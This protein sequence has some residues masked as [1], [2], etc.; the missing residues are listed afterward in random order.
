MLPIAETVSLRPKSA[1]VRLTCATILAAAASFPAPMM[2]QTATTGSDGGAAPAAGGAATGGGLL[3]STGAPKA[4][5]DDGD[6]AEEPAQKGVRFG[7]S[8]WVTT[9][10]PF[11][12]TRV[13]YSDNADLDPR[14]QEE[15]DFTSSTTVGFIADS[16]SRRLDLQANI[17][18]TYDEYLDDTSQDG[19]TVRGDF[20]GRAEVLRNR[21]FLDI[22]GSARSEPTEG[23][24]ALSLNETAAEDDR[25][26]TY[27]VGI[28]PSYVQPIDGVG[29]LEARYTFTTRFG[30][31]DAEES[32]ASIYEVALRTDPQLLDGA[33]LEAAA[34]FED[35]N[36]DEDQDRDI[37]TFS[38]AGEAPVSRTVAVI[39]AV[40][41]DDVD[42]DPDIGG[43]VSGAFGLAGLRYAP[44]SRLDAS[45]AAGVRYNRL[46]YRADFDY[47]FNSMWSFSAFGARELDVDGV[48]LQ[49][50]VTLSRKRANAERVAGRCGG[51]G[52]NDDENGTSIDDRIAFDLAVEF[53]K[54]TIGFSGCAEG[55]D[56][57]DDR[58]DEFV[59]DLALRADRVLPGTRWTLGGVMSFS[60]VEASLD[61]EV[62]TDNLGVGVTAA[63]QLTENVSVF[64]QYGFSQRFADDADEEYLENFGL[65]GIRGEL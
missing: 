50:A 19:F 43:D 15:D 26:Q 24:A 31:G 40:G 41:F 2:A 33:T 28:S 6:A 14:G 13:I 45:A 5:A 36:S 35:F 32:W 54:T 17:G 39:G 7:G 1:I 12:E 51:L 49:R 58:G 22:F 4:D 55:R 56:F 20:N 65:I 48:G 18:V 8:G 42:P 47:A 30:D 53:P 59:W 64:A 9:I 44:N 29:D 61:G 25:E 62:D 38:L 34:R 46:S 11:V 27:Q 10:N 52:A 23:N 3:G 63:Y 60:H 57:G 16:E 21:G 37:L